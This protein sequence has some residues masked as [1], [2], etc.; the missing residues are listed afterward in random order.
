MQL[1]SG[2]PSPLGPLICKHSALLPC[3][4]LTKEWAR[5]KHTLLVARPKIFWVASCAIYW[6]DKSPAPF[7]SVC[8]PSKCEIYMKTYS[9]PHRPLSPLQALARSKQRNKLTWNVEGDYTQPI[10]GP[11]LT[12]SWR[13][14]W[15]LSK[16]GVKS[17]QAP[18]RPRS[19]MLL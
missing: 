14:S 2:A 11:T 13:L 10:S 7:W 1:S 4:P 3:C 8:C 5:R 16:S 9:P 12:A 6:A 17:L 19:L 18:H 15:F